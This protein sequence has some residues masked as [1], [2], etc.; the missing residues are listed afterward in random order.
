M[1]DRYT[2]Q[3]AYVRDALIDFSRRA[4]LTE[5]DA[6]TILTARDTLMTF[7]I[8]LDERAP[9]D[10]QGLRDRVRVLE[11]EAA[12][13][14]AFQ[15]KQADLGVKDMKRIMELEAAL[16]VAAE[17]L[18]CCYNVVDYPGDGSS[19]AKALTIARA[20]LTEPGRRD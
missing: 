16:E 5:R 9:E 3:A 1:A 17:A 6:R 15:L 11:A 14:M 4:A 12:E 7:A 8:E 18:A 10:V 20:A 2:K 19:Q 13:R